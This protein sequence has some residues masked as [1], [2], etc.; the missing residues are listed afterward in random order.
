[1]EVIGSMR[2][3]CHRHVVG[4]W[5]NGMLVVCV[6]MKEEVFGMLR[7]SSGLMLL[8]Q[9]SLLSSSSVLKCTPIAGPC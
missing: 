4:L 2:V 8:L 5:D 3:E 1:M 6:Y 7:E 9:R